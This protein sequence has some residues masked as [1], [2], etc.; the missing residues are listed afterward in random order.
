MLRKVFIIVLLCFSVSFTMTTSA[1]SESDYFIAEYFFKEVEMTY[2]WFFEVFTSAYFKA[3]VDMWSG[4]SFLSGILAFIMS[5]VFL[6]LYVVVAAV[7]LSVAT[8]I[9]G[10]AIGLTIL[11]YLCYWLAIMARFFFVNT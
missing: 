6:A 2:S 8:C 7:F 11:G 3:F 9:A 1:C 10:L 5:I 4:V